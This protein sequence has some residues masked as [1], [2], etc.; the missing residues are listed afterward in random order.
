VA[1]EIG[2]L[3]RSEDGDECAQRRLDQRVEF[4]RIGSADV[5]EMQHLA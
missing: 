1:D 2:H 4:E 3:E 5:H